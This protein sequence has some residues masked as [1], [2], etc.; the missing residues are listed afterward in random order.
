MSRNYKVVAAV[1]AIVV[2]AYAGWRFHESRRARN[3]GLLS[4]K[5]V[6]NGDVWTADFSARIP[7]TEPAVFDAIKDVEKSQSDQVKSVKVV[8]E[9]GNTKVVDMELAGPGGQPMMMRLAFTYLPDERRINYHTV[10]NPALDTQAEYKLDDDGADTLLSV[11]QTTKFGQP[12]PLPDGVVE[13]IIRGIFVAQ[14]EGLDHALH[15]TMAEPSED[16]GDEP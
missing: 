5:I 14:L 12:I 10:D 15:I 11:H 4:E 8:S 16:N 6:H 3:A 2:I 13:Q 1:V 7:A 9:R